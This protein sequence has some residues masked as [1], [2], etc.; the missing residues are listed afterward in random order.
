MVGRSIRVDET[1][2]WQ[3]GEKVDMV[4]GL[5]VFHLGL[6]LA[7]YAF[8]AGGWGVVVIALNSAGANPDLDWL[9]PVFVSAIVAWAFLLFGLVLGLRMLRKRNA[10]EVKAGYTTARGDHREVAQVDHRT[11]IVFREAGSPF[12][13]ASELSETI[14]RLR[15]RNPET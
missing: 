8:V 15:E 2:R 14:R 13:S 11:G 1:K 12:L 3:L 5:S 4:P 10:E 7:V 6:R 9:R